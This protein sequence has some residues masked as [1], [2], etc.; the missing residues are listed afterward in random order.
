LWAQHQIE[1]SAALQIQELALWHKESCK[2]TTRRNSFQCNIRKNI[3]QP[4]KYL[5]KFHF[6]IYKLV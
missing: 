4:T 2:P 6:G 1:H 3:C 5:K